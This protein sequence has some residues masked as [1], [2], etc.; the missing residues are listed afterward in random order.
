M[1][2]YS[3]NA[4]GTSHRVWVL[5]VLRL[6]RFELACMHFSTTA[7]CDQQ[8]EFLIG[9]PQWWAITGSYEPHELFLCKSSFFGWY[10]ITA[11][12]T[13]SGPLPSKELYTTVTVESRMIL[14][15]LALM[16]RE[17]N[18]KLGMVNVTRSS[19]GSLARRLFPT[20]NSLSAL[21]RR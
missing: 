21:A 4:G 19:D 9:C 16:N 17:A 11:T 8:F 2:K 3:L 10:F 15:W 6:E 20:D 14:H 18:L 1:G 7:R 5:G 13:K 12:E